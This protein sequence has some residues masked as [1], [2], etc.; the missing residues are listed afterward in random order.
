MSYTAN[1]I[2]QVNFPN[3]VGGYGYL[4]NWYAVNTVN[5][6]P[7]GWHVP[8]RAEMDTLATFLGG[9]TVAGGKLKETG[10]IHF[11]SPNIDATDDYSY[12]AL[13]GGG[14]DT[15]GNFVAIRE[16]G[17]YWEN[18]A[19]SSVNAYCNNI[20]R[21]DALLQRYIN[22]K[23]NGQSV[24]LIKDDSTNPG[25]LT[26]YDNNVYDT[27]NINGQIWITQNWKC[28]RLNNGTALTK[29]TDKATWE[30]RITEAYCSYN[31]NDNYV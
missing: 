3:Q 20:R 24:R 6:A 21:Q 22:P 15:Y 5:F 9:N 2:H 31:N 28:T 7:S 30:T 27:I 14:R 26:D 12:S 19:S 1:I 25:T 4:Y 10:I 17:I 18:Q 29:I 11:N 23:N 8:T 13:P 16:Y